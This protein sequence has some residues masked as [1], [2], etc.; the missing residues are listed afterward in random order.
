MASGLVT[1]I[2]FCTASGGWWNE[3]S[4]FRK[5]GS[6]SGVTRSA[7]QAFDSAPSNVERRFL[8]VEEKSPDLRPVFADRKPELSFSSLLLLRSNSERR[9]RTPSELS[10]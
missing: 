2:V 3:A 9:L 1:S 8:K 6:R 5:S 7:V 4:L 10:K